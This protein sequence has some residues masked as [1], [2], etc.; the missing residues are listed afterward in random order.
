[1]TAPCRVRRGADDAHRV[2]A[3]SHGRVH[4]PRA[5]RA[6]TRSSRTRAITADRASLCHCRVT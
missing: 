2:T 6:S 1:M 5:R 4:C 3:L